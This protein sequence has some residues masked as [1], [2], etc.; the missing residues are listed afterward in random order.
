MIWTVLL[1]LFVGMPLLELA[2]LLKVGEWIGAFPT[3]AIVI[4][5][6]V[7]GATLAKLEGWRVM[8]RIQQELGQGRMPA[9]YLLDGVMILVAGVMLITPGFITDVVGFLLLMAPFRMLMKQ[10]LK[11]KIEQ[12][13]RRDAIDVTYVEW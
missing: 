6:G 1:L 9:P 2:V 11:S 5:T 3:F 10:W 7:L 4:L 13:I 12:N 8:L